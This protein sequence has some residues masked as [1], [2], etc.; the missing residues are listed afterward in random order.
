M[1]SKL[2]ELQKI[3]AIDCATVGG[4]K[5][6]HILA[7]VSIVDFNGKVI[8]DTFVSPETGVRDYRF[9]K[10]G[11]K[12]E[13]LIGVPSFSAVQKIVNDILSDKIVVGHNLHFDLIILG[14]TTSVDL[15]R[16][17]S[18]NGFIFDTFGPEDVSLKKLSKIILQRDI[19]IGCND[20]IENA[21][22]V[23]DIY[24]YFQME[25]DEGRDRFPQRKI[26]NMELKSSNLTRNLLIGGTIL[27]GVLALTLS[28]FGHRNYKNK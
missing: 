14:I 5:N 13:N 11:V 2:N 20:S 15:L 27:G 22:A 16:D 12:Q 28:I 21:K 3:V 25:I 18:T 4:P 17:I 7:R 1:S 8:F 24:K 19:Q 26:E 9:K 10:S 6:Q 23:L